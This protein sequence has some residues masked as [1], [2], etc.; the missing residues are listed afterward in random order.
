MAPR[1]RVRGCR[2]RISSSDGTA[3]PGRQLTRATPPLCD[4]VAIKMLIGFFYQKQQSTVNWHGNSLPHC[5][6][7]ETSEDS[8]RMCCQS[9]NNKTA[10]KNKRWK[11]CVSL[12]F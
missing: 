7:V 3:T 11:D 4:D 6:L 10:I 9:S 8:N 2:C 5:S 12:F 1:T